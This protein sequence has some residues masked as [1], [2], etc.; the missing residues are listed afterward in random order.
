MTVCPTIR[1]SCVTLLTSYP[2]PSVS[3]SPKNS[4]NTTNYRHKTN[5]FPKGRC[6]LGEG[7]KFPL[8]ELRPRY[9]CIHCHRQLHPSSMGCSESPEEDGRVRCKGG[10][11]HPTICLPVVNQDP[12]QALNVGESPV[13]ITS[14]TPIS[15]NEPILGPT[16]TV[17]PPSKRRRVNPDG[18]KRGMKI[19]GGSPLMMT[20]AEWYSVCETYVNLNIKMKQAEFLRSSH[21]HY[22]FVHV[23]RAKSNPS[24]S[25]KMSI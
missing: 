20:M 8:G 2:P 17:T 16:T 5:M 12:N 19:G 25:Y 23:Q 9:K 13:S 1:P 14:P 7:C 15:N 6:S 3:T 22:Y 21:A 4:S 24:P 18:K 11:G 10:C